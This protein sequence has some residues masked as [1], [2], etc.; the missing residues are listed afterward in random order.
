[1]HYI[2]LTKQK[3]KILL[4]LFL[5]RKN[6]NNK[7]NSFMIFK[8]HFMYFYRGFFFSTLGPRGGHSPTL[9]PP[10]VRAWLDIEWVGKRD[11]KWFGELTIAYDVASGNWWSGKWPN[12]WDEVISFYRIYLSLWFQTELHWRLTISFFSLA[13]ILNNILNKNNFCLIFQSF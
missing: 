8:L 6:S 1:M 7:L 3:L 10:W 4:P 5:V 12:L 2:M 9:P 11:G 13:L